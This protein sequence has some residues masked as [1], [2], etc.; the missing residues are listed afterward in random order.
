[1]DYPGKE[2]EIF[3]KA[4][5]WRKY[6]HFLVKNYLKE[7]LLEVGAGIGSFTN[8]YKNDFS[9]ITL[10]ELDKS[11]IQKLSEKFKNT[12]IK[13]NS[14]YT[15]NQTNKFNTILYMNVLE[16]IEK[17]VEEINIAL[18]KLNVD[19]HLIILVPAHNELFTKFDKE[20]GHFRR[21]KVD[22][23]QNLNIGQNEILKLHYLDCFGYF[24]YFLNKIFFKDEIYP[25]KFKIFIWDKI[26]TP[27]TIIIDKIFR[28]RYGKNILCIIKKK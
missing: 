18:E 6:V 9:D 14:N 10:T 27:F 15:S 28:Y 3:D 16:H 1:M 22:F 7:A 24:L 11:N 23:F 4:T 8:N 13:I 26:F 2:L 21:Y 12:K 17:D 19:G 5:I 20:I 25:S